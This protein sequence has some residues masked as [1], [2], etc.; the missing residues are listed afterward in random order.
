M[1]DP[2]SHLSKGQLRQRHVLNRLVAVSV[3]SA[4]QADAVFAAPLGLR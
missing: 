4:A 3:M 1:Y 2:L